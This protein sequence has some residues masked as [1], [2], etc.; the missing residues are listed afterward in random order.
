MSFDVQAAIAQAAS[1]GP[2]LS[3]TSTGGGGSYTPPNKGKCVAILVGYVE[4]GRQKKVW[5]GKESFPRKAEFIFELQGGV[6]PVEVTEEGTR[7]AKRITVGVTLPDPGKLPNEKSGFAKLFAALNYDADA[8]HP[9][10]L[11]G[12]HYLVDVQHDVVQKEGKDPVTYAG[13][14]N[15]QDRFYIEK[16]VIM[17]GDPLSGAMEEKPIAKPEAVSALRLF[18]W[19]FP[20]KEMWDSLYIDGEYPERKDEKTGKVISPAR[21]KNVIQ[22]KIMQAKDW[23]ESQMAEILSAGQ[24][25]LP[26]TTAPDVPSNSGGASEDPLA[27]IG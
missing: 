22:L 7:I 11:L 9:A 18:L 3:K 20:S 16:P 25:D 8:T 21:S 12:R 10:Q 14:G 6:N 2:D 4:L 26:P 5:Q 24:L 27:N 23:P 17:S 1:Q 15:A 19:D 13:L